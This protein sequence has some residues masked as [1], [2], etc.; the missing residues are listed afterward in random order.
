MQAA[1]ITIL[2]IL[3]I[4]ALVG[5]FYGFLNIV[6]SLLAW[7][8]ASGIA[9]KTTPLFATLLE[10]HVETP[11]IR[12]VLA[13]AGIFIISLMI[14]SALG[15]F[16]VK[17]LGRAGLTAADRILGLL[18]GFGLGLTIVGAVVFLAGFTA[19]P[20]EQWWNESRLIAPFEKVSV[21]G[22]QYLPE[23]MAKHHGYEFN[24]TPAAP[25]T[26]PVE[27]GVQS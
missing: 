27:P 18:F 12:T 26:E 2:V 4:P 5:V 11:L 16:I 1:D 14:F 9:V 7:V 22:H 6:F 15:Y 23:S 19:F 8:L 24:E 21:W 10:N 17:L 20:K 13:F 3:A 25:V